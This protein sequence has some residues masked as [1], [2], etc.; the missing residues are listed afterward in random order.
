MFV[1]RAQSRRLDNTVGLGDT[2][3]APVFGNDDVS[4]LSPPCPVVRT[5]DELLPVSREKLVQAQKKDQIL[6]KCLSTVVT[7]EQAEAQAVAYFVEEGL[8]LRKW[9]PGKGVE[10]SWSSVFQIV[11]PHSFRSRL[12][13]LAHDLPW[14]GH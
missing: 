5:A 9:T 7:R 13:L 4:G 12:L 3:F 14:A 10:D 2:V 11:V 8:L 1:T 6:I